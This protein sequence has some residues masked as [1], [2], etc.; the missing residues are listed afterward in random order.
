MSDWNW[1]SLTMEQLMWAF[2][3]VEFKRTPR[4]HQMVSLAFAA[5]KERVA[6]W[7]GVGTGK[8]LAAYYT[9]MLWG[10]EKI[11]VVAPKSALS[12]WIRDNQWTDYS[13]KLI[14]GTT[15]ERKLQMQGKQNVSII[16]YESLKTVFAEF[17]IKNTKN[18]KTKKRAWIVNPAF[19]GK[20]D[21]IIFD[22]M[23][24]CSSYSSLQSE[25]AL[26]LSK[27]SKHVIG[28]TGTPV[29]RVLL[30]LFNIYYV[31]DLGKVL[32]KSFWKFRLDHFQK[33]FF[34][35][36]IKAGHKEKILKK[37]S[38]ITLSFSSEECMD[39]P[40]CQHEEVLVDPTEEFLKLEKRVITNRPIQLLN[41]Q[42]IFPLPSVKG[43]KLKQLTGGFIYL[44]DEKE[45]KVYRLSENPKLE[46]LL[47]ILQNG[48]KTIIFY[49]FLE[50]GK[51]ICEALKKQ[52]IHFSVMQGGMSL[53]DRLEEE[54][55]FQG[56][57]NQVILVQISGGSEGW[58]GFSA[59]V[60]IF[61]DIVA[62]P[63]LRTQCVGRMVRSGQTDPTVVYELMLSG[64]INEV[65]KNNQTDRKSEIDGIMEYLRNY[66]L[67][68]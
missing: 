59:K 65:T 6:F 13:Y 21:C 56:G 66:E 63:K 54:R 24:R 49:E 41:S 31:L 28:L 50:A 67:R 22:E 29:D 33:N 11:L 62:S 35:F 45:R 23:H 1:K 42:D 47:D 44:G 19:F 25:I 26:E 12:S 40:P 10:C 32:G 46:V 2:Q 7:H 18:T 55:K 17:R 53:E 68:N 52:K 43:T 16:Q 61:W 39:L 58:D 51:I 48:E 20:F 8:T 38:P 57:G 36:S 37:V 60:M 30:E 5:E 64:S 27:R 14:S 9:A 4:W 3:G 15:E 34:D